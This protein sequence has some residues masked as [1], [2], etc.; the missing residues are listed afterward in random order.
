MTEA[1]RATGVVATWA[2]WATWPACER[3]IGLGRGALEDGCLLGVGLGL[4]DRALG[5]LGRKFVRPVGDERVDDGLQWDVVGLG[6][7][8]DRLATGQGRVEF[9]LGDPDRRGNDR[10]VAHRFVM[11]EASRATGVVAIVVRRRTGR[12][13]RRRCGGQGGCRRRAR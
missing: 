3:A 6:H 13:R 12:S 8:G 1:S 5:D 10:G 4:G 7:V 9:G 11:T 2:T